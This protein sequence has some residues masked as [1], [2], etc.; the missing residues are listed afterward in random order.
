MK[1]H[2]LSSRLARAADVPSLDLRSR[3]SQLYEWAQTSEFIFGSPL[4]PIGGGQRAHYLPSFVYFGP[5]TSEA[6]PRLA[7]L[8]GLGRHDLLA[9]RAV[10]AFVEG[11]ARQP[12]IG[13]ALNV[14]LFP[15]ANVRGLLEGAEERDLSEEHWGRSTAPEIRLLA[16]DAQS[17]S[18][19]GYI[20][21][22]TTTDDEP[23]AWLRS[24]VS[25]FVARSGIEVF[26]SADFEP[27]T[28]RFESLPSS[29]ISRGPL[30]LADD[31]PFAP[32]EVELA[33][34]ADWPQA[35]ADR[36]LS[37]LLKRLLTRYRGFLAYG[38]NL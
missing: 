13:H 6:S 23:S 36:E 20:R 17:K 7:V 3:F 19:Q 22:S 33:L 8:S 30:S 29:V 1:S 11:L 28:V 37:R 4:G 32:F 2:A 5:Q 12:D 31:L 35:R 18:Y 27:W 10:T 25:P 15:V 26:N 34:P 24:V 16:S 21:I 14:S 38:L 9:A